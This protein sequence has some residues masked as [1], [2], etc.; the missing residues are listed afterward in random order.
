MHRVSLLS[1]VVLAGC[2][3]LRPA[4]TNVREG[5]HVAFDL[6]DAGR[7]AMSR[8]AGPE[9][10]NMEGR[11]ISADNTDYTLSVKSVRFLRGGEQVWAGERVRIPKEHVGTAWERRFSPGRTAAFAAAT[12]GAVAAFVITR[13]LLTGGDEPGG[14]RPDEPL[15][16]F[17][18]PPARITP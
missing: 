4:G 15:G 10:L 2:Y 5:S 13:E 9:I 3:T 18:W 14:N 17:T 1:F 6:N 11:L 7:M 12:V 16:Q 8:H